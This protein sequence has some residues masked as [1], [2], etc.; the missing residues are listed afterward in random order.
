MAKFY[1]NVSA[2]DGK[3]FHRY[4]EDGIKKK[5][6]V[7]KYPYKMYSVSPF[8]TSDMLSLYG[9]RLDEHTFD[10]I[11]SLRNYCYK[12]PEAHGNS[13]PVQQFIVGNYTKD[14]ICYDHSLY[15]VLNFDLE[16]WHD[17]GFPDPDAALY[18]ILSVSFDIVGK[19]KPFT[20]GLKPYTKEN[21]VFNYQKFDSEAELL[22]AFINYWCMVQPEAYTGWN[23]NGGLKPFDIPYLINRIEKVLG[24]GRSN[25][26]SPFSAHSKNCI[27]K[28][29]KYNHYNIAGVS[30]L[31]YLQL[32]LK[33]STT[34][35]ESNKLGFVGQH[36]INSGKVD[37]NEYNNNLM[38]LY[39]GRYKV[40]GD[41]DSLNTKDRW[42]RLKTKIEDN[43][44]I[45]QHTEKQ[46]ILCD[47]VLEKYENVVDNKI[48]N[49]T[50]IGVIQRLYNDISNKVAQDS[51]NVFVEYNTQDSVIV[52]GLD[53][54]LGFIRLAF[55]IAHIASSPLDDIF[56]TIK[57]WDNMIHAFLNEKGVV[58]PPQK[59]YD[60]SDTDEDDTQYLGGYVK[61]PIAGRY[62]WAVSVDLTSL[63][64]SIIM[65]LNMSPEKLV[66]ESSDEPAL[67]II[68]SMIKFEYDTSKAKDGGFAIAANGSM[69]KQDS[70]GVIPAIMQMLFDTRKTTKKKLKVSENEL[71]GLNDKASSG[72]VVAFNLINAKKEE[73]ALLDSSQHAYKILANSGYGAIGNKTFRYY[74]EDIAEGITSTG[75][76][77]IKFIAKSINDMLNKEFQTTGFEY[78]IYIDTDSVTGE[79]ILTTPDGKVSIA[80]FYEKYCGKVL[81]Q[82]KDNYTVLPNAPVTVLSYDEKSGKAVQKKVVNM[83]K[84]LV[85]KQMFKLTVGGKSVVVTQDHSLVVMRN[86][87][88]VEVKPNEVRRDDNFVSIV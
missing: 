67:S 60:K 36:E 57:A 63:Y 50:P 33:Y 10:D 24:R 46:E 1:T 78:V 44:G 68:E 29:G 32:Y 28:K 7:S 64:P 55:T 56:G 39:L 17:N 84:H 52:T 69:Y 16:V 43:F 66:A 48:D 2:V 54:K 41:K 3:I 74:L 12:N 86:G 27:S 58:P 26:L 4:I 34:K 19:T 6:V 31:D 83:K 21:N 5:E 72:D 80:E 49:D 65:M 23:T 73:I 20:Y 77:A 70:I 71:E 35:L 13:S 38:N 40:R 76:L 18:E 79:T 59:Q 85:K 8:G 15:D 53:R 51:F 25:V 11:K 42:C 62:N 30:N 45:T 22:Q 37:F 87:V 9:D 82:S 61:E 81:Q 14:D 88:L 47:S 75:Q